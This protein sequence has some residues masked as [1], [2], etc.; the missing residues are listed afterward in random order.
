MHRISVHGFC[1]SNTKCAII[2]GENKNKKDSAMAAS[3]LWVSEELEYWDSNIRFTHIAATYSELVAIST[4][5]QL[6]QWRWAD[7]HPYQR[8]DV[9]LTMLLLLYHTIIRYVLL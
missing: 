4:Q 1:K 3:P 7:A 8:A 5:G 9:C 6:H 2:S